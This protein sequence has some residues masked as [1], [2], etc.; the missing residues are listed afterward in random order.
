MRMTSRKIMGVRAR[1]MTMKTEIQTIW[2]AVGPTINSYATSA[3]PRTITS[4]APLS[5]AVARAI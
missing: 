2:R 4:D 3:V 1:T 5:A